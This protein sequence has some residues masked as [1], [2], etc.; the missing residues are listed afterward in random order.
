MEVILFTLTDK[1]LSSSPRSKVAHLYGVLYEKT[2]FC[3]TSSYCRTTGVERAKACWAYL[4]AAGKVRRLLLIFVP[5]RD[6]IAGVS[7]IRVNVYQVHSCNRGI[8]IHFCLKI[9]DNSGLDT[10]SHR[11][12]KNDGYLNFECRPSISLRCFSSWQLL[13]HLAPN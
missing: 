7:H 11:I 13:V 6:K 1:F 5:S 3:T 8:R 12:N 9:R 4:K 2:Y 10:I